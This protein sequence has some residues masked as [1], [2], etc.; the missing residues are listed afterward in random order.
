MVPL[1]DQFYA[2]LITVLI[3]LIAGFCYDFYRVTRSKFGLRKAGTYLGD[4]IFWLV[5]TA[6]VFGLLLA[7]N[8]GEVRLYVFIGLVLGALIYAKFLSRPG[9]AVIN[10]LFHILK[11][12]LLG[13]IKVLAAL[14]LIFCFPFR[15]TFLVIV[16]PFHLLGLLMGKLLQP[17]KKMIHKYVGNP[18][19]E[20]KR[21]LFNRLAVFFNQHGKKD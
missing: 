9:I 13:L 6:L 19:V 4:I 12:L 10:G 11:M 21:R 3:G 16:T 8:W 2:F 17:V 14:W 7:G 20:R 18:L 15:L 1:T 5:L